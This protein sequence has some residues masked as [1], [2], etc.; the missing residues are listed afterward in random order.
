MRLPPIP[1]SLRLTIET[2]EGEHLR[3]HWHLPGGKSKRRFRVILYG[4]IGAFWL[5]LAV[6]AIWLRRLATYG[7]P[8]LL[9]AGVCGLVALRMLVH[10][11]RLARRTGD[12]E[13]TLGREIFYYDPGAGR[14][15]TFAMHSDVTAVSQQGTACIVAM[16]KSRKNLWLRPV[17]RPHWAITIHCAS[18][19]AAAWLVEA[20]NRWLRET[21]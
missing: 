12:T 4:I 11:V 1:D 10:L 9:W 5:Y 7:F 2:S 13:L 17:L 3:I 8:Q 20:L 18:P 19:M 15:Q 21:W 14:G 16:R 6:D